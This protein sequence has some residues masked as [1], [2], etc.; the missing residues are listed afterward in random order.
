MALFTALVGRRATRTGTWVGDL[1]ECLGGAAEP[2][3]CQVL[4]DYTRC[5]V[6]TFREEEGGEETPVCPE[7]HCSPNLNKGWI[8]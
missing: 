8:C 3:F 5:L 1:A 7:D 2:I 4:L 6:T